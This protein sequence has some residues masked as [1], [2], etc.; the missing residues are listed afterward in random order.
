MVRGDITVT[1]VRDVGER[2]GVDVNDETTETY[3]Y[4]I[5]AD[6]INSVVRRSIGAVTDRRGSIT[7]DSGWRFVAPNPGVDCWTVWLSTR[8]IFLLIPVDDDTVYAYASM[9][10]GGQVGE[11]PTWLERT[12][13]EYPSIVGEAIR[14]ALTSGAPLRRSAVEEIRLDKWSLGRIVLV[15]DAAHA[16]APVWAQ[17]AAMAAEDALVIAHELVA[18]RTLPG[19]WHQAGSEYERRRRNRV[20]HVKTMTDTVSQAAG[21]PDDVRNQVLPEAGPLSFAATYGPLR[22]S[23]LIST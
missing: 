8:G 5:G 21:L 23:A 13:R 12:F 16:T 6:G 2:I 3:D 22:E 20:D 10:A 19:T 9:A 1:N 11:D 14:N 15:G 4:V 18:R 7:S 17:G